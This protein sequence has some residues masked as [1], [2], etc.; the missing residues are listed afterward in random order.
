MNTRRNS[1]LELLRILAML[2]IICSHVYC[3]CILD[4]L[5][6]A[7]HSDLYC[8]PAFYKS[9]GIL[10]IMA[11]TG[12]IGNTIFILISGYF[13][14]SKEPSSINLTKIGQKLLLQ[15]GFATTALVITSTIVINWANTS[16]IN[17]NLNSYMTFFSF[18]SMS[19]FVGYY[20]IVILLGKLFLN[21]K[22]DKLEKEKYLMLL[23]TFFAIIQFS[24]SAGLLANLISGLDTVI[25]GLFL[26][27]LGGYIRKFNPFEKVRLWI[28]FALIILTNIVVYINY[29][30]GT[31]KS[32][33]NFNPDDGNLFMQSIPGYGN[34]N[35]VTLILGITIFEIFR[36]IPSFSCKIINF[37][38]AATFMVY[39]MHDNE[40]FYSLWKTE[41]WL[42]LLYDDKL[43]FFLTFTK[44]M[45]I[46]FAS[47]LVM[48]IVYILIGM[49]LKILRPLAIKK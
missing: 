40:F 46:T 26:Y 27:S 39:L 33:N 12:T 8:N 1:N 48:Y 20:F 14:A 43:A 37:I 41:D 7:W 22:L 16:L 24:W 28:L 10:A 35:I 13:M 47:G 29:Y 32:I 21:S 45:G 2:M 23:V 31:I 34:N 42:P 18:N 17:V 15:L 49:L 38:S 44:W 9:L 19:W 4:Q 6:G 30:L 25:T 36:R 5:N 11:P 3:H